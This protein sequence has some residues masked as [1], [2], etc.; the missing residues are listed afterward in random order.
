LCYQSK[1]VAFCNR[2]E[3][4]LGILDMIRFYSYAYCKMLTLKQDRKGVTAMEY[5][6]LA[7]TTVVVGLAAIA[8]IGTSIA[9]IFGNIHT[10]LAV[11][12]G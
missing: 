8:G 9:T 7:G 2:F 5:G 10:S 12:A 6:L 11:A 1:P 3:D 4:L